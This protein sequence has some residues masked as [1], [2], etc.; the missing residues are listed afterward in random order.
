MLKEVLL[1]FVS[2]LQGR[3]VDIRRIFP[4]VFIGPFVELTVGIDTSSRTAGF[5]LVL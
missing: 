3:V 5:E 4:V 2:V 1:R